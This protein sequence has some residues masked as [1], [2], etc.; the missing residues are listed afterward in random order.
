MESTSDDLKKPA[1]MTPRQLSIHILAVK[2]MLIDFNCLIEEYRQ[3]V[4][5]AGE[6]LPNMKMWWT[7]LLDLATEL[8][9]ALDQKMGP[10]MRLVDAKFDFSNADMEDIVG[11]I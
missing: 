6:N 7:G 4:D 11:E 3:T 1:N 5:N 9:K 8:E 10:L 2:M